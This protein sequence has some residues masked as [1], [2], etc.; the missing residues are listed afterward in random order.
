ML[1]VTRTSATEAE[2]KLI[3]G[4]ELFRPL[5][6]FRAY[7]WM[8]TAASTL[9]AL[10]LTYV[11][12]EK[13]EVKK[14]IIFKPFEVTRIQGYETQTF[15]APAPAAPYKIIGATLDQLVQ[16]DLVLGDVVKKLRLDV[17]EPR[18]YSGPF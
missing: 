15:G 9:G 11:Y 8:F 4:R 13:Y 6:T 3:S 7:I 10:A 1:D 2:T 14:A 17:P 18:V 12:S 16:S 5:R